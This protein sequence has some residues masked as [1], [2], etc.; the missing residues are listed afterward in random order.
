MIETSEA[1]LSFCREQA[2]A[3]FITVDTEFI[4]DKTFWPRLCLIQVAGPQSAAVIDTLAEGLDLAPLYALF[5]DD[6]ILKVFHAARQDLEIFF[7]ERGRLPHPVFDTQ[8]AAM[9]CG[10]GD[11]IGYDRLAAQ[12]AG[13][14]I[15]KSSRFTDWARRPLTRKQLDYALSDVTHLRTV[16][17][18]LEKKLEKNNRTHWLTEEMEILLHH[19][20]YDSSPERAWLRLKTRSRDRR[21]L[22]TLR[23][24]AAWR[25]REA[26]ER[27]LPRNRIVRDEQLYDIA[28]QAPDSPET[29]ARTRGLG[30]DFARG[31]LGR[32]ILEAIEQAKALPESEL[33][34]APTREDAPQSTGATAELLKV[35]LKQVCEA[36]GVAQR[37]VANAADLEALAGNDEAEVAALKGW[38][39]ELFGEQALAL[40]H[41][42]IALAIDRAGAVRLVPL[43]S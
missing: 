36:H 5:D 18:K 21:Y 41:G 25:E 24:V 7:H 32:G 2:A 10:F 1:L 17:D 29:L 12:L 39:R 28:A 22:A 35:L 8:V 19:D 31:K 30:S 6:R 9:V 27:D 34:P 16:Y 11:Q 40:K 3:Q 26:Q 42:R 4:R 43:D 23:E 13:A 37:L 14:R 15:D 20:T 38:R 33:P